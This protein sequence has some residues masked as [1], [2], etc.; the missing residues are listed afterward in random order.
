MKTAILS[1]SIGVLATTAMAQIPNH[2]FEDWQTVGNYEVPT[3]W[4]TMNGLSGT[5]FNS[6]TKSTDHYP[7]NVGQYSVRLENNTSLT[8]FTGA[9]GTIATGG[10]D[11]PLIPAFA[12]ESDP[13]SFNGYYKYLPMNGDEAWLTVALFNNGVEVA[14]EQITTGET[15]ND[16]TA[17]SFPLTGYGT[18]DSAFIMAF[19]F[20]PESQ[21]DGPNGNS[22]LYLDNL[23]FDQAITGV[24]S[25]ESAIQ[26][27]VYPNPCSDMVNVT[28]KDAPSASAQ[29]QIATMQGAAISKYQMQT[30]TTRLDVSG[31]AAGSYLLSVVSDKGVKTQ[32]LSVIR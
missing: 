26:L 32:R 4:A 7:A 24:D 13:T 20:T 3:G 22:V 31:L 17:F 15:V 28:V 27:G 16:W 23:S 1:I 21:L 12:L 5:S 18:A 19:A 14:N 29:I 30:E 10:F 6:C 25:P 11:W 9:Y 2:G 8:Q